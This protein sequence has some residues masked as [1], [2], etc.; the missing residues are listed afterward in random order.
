VVKSDKSLSISFLQLALV[1]GRAGSLGNRYVAISYGD[2]QLS[3][4][5][6][7]LSK[8]KTS[9][10]DVSDKLTNF[11]VQESK[12]AILSIDF[13]NQTYIVDIT[14]IN[15]RPG[16]LF[17][18]YQFR[19]PNLYAEKEE[20]VILLKPDETVHRYHGLNYS[21]FNSSRSYGIPLSASLNDVKV[22]KEIKINGKVQPCL[23]LFLL[24]LL[25]VRSER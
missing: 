22:E 17:G 1:K 2:D 12:D 19:A 3:T 5:D 7:L 23:P 13:D 9:T 21:N 18:L 11:T 25:L 6:V 14:I 20:S 10:L 24:L 8:N 15:N 16:Y 4:Y